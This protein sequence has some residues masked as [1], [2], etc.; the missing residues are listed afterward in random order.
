[1]WTLSSLRLQ[2]ASA[3]TLSMF[4]SSLQR[5]PLS[6]LS[7]D[8]L[9]SFFTETLEAFEENIHILTLPNPPTHLLLHLP[10]TPSFP[11]AARRELSFLVAKAKPSI[12]ASVSTQS[13]LVGDFD[14]S[15]TLHHYCFP[16]HR[17]IVISIHT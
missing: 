9:P 10:P 1:M 2:G 13:L 5:S 11:P 8:D 7:D 4:S 16:L 3:T 15:T 12:C 6:S 14:P 17:I